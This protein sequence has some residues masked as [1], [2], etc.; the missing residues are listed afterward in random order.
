M[1]AAIPVYRTSSR[2][3]QRER[4]EMPQPEGDVKVYA[5]MI[6]PSA[7]FE[8]AEI[9]GN[10]FQKEWLSPDASLVSNEGRSFPVQYPRM[11]LAENQVKYLMERA[12]LH[13]K[14]IPVRLQRQ[15]R[16]AAEVCVADYLFFK[17]WDD[18]NPVHLPKKACT[19]PAKFQ[20]REEESTK[21][22]KEKFDSELLRQQASRAESEANR[23]KRK[24]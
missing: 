20:E 14:R 6:L 16:C 8:S 10:S 7:P 24:K 9:A 2:K 22:E 4:S 18:F 12:K 13:T 21:T 1:Q 5:A 15:L 19:V 23:S 11:N 17:P 3:P